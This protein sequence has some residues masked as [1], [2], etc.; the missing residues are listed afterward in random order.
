MPAFS[1]IG[2]GLHDE[3]GMTLEGLE[4]AKRS[5]VAF[6]EFYTNTMP[7]LNL[8]RLELQIEKKIRVLDRTQLEDEG[9][10]ELLRA[11]KDGRAVLLVP[12]D[13]MIAT[14]H[15]SLRLSL[16]KM[17]IESRIIHAASIISAISGAT[18]LQSYKFGKSV[19]VPFDYPLPNSVL[20]T[21][22]EN[23]QRGLHTLLLL[24]VKAD[25]GRQLTISEAL[26]K[27]NK[28][29]SS[30]KNQLMVGAARLGSPDEKIKAARSLALASEDFGGPPHSIVAVG[31]LHFMET[32]ALKV[33]CGAKDEDLRESS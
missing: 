28:G 13:P 33:L 4:E 19:T 7:N 9:G 16:A 5:D 21:I 32:E 31:K 27:I 14:T 8:E 18:G 25:Q 29:D 6:A 12:G 26:S 11:A 20:T 17:G 22:S 1:F 24:D 2:L 15:V 23:R 30:L 10:R 3:K